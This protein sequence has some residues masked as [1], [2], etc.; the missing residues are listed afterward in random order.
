M[1]GSD[2]ILGTDD[3]IIL[4]NTTLGAA[5]RSIIGIS[6]GTDMGSPYGSGLLEINHHVHQRQFDAFRIHYRN[7]CKY[8]VV[9]CLAWII[10]SD[11]M[12]ESYSDLLHLELQIETQLGLMKELI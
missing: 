11:L 3:G 1:L 9:K 12:M 7:K 10:Y 5:D 8:K 2:N 6:E 4:G